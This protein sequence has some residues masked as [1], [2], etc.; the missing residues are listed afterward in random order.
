VQAR[1]EEIRTIRRNDPNAYEADKKMQ[2]EELELIE[3]NLKM[4][5]RGRA[6]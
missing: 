6:A 3:A 5:K 1:L 2:A 4:E